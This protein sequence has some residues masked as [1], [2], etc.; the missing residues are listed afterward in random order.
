VVEPLGFVRPQTLRKLAGQLQKYRGTIV[1]MPMIASE[2]VIPFAPA[3]AEQAQP[4]ELRCFT[5]DDRRVVFAAMLRALDRCGCWREVMQAT[6]PTQVEICFT[7]LLSA[8]DELYGGLVGAGA[9]MTRDTHQS[10]TWLCTLR[11]HQPEELRL[12][13]AVDVRLEM[14]FLI[15]DDIAS[16]F[17]SAGLA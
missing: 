8:T 5:Y 13:G 4:V 1:N 10:L 3:A 15:E 14:S 16:G 17:I 6:S 2:T 7:V 11:R 12:Y 9:E